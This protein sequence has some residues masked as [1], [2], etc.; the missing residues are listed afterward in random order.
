MRNDFQVIAEIPAITKFKW[1]QTMNTHTHTH[2]TIGLP[3]IPMIKSNLCIFC[4]YTAIY[5][6]AKHTRTHIHKLINLWESSINQ[7]SMNSSA[8]WMQTT[9]HNCLH[10][11]SK[12]LQTKWFMATTIR[13]Y[14]AYDANPD[15]HWIKFIHIWSEAIKHF[16]KWITKSP[17]MRRPTFSLPYISFESS[18]KHCSIDRIYH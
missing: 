18:L 6:N 9:L 3:S 12:M 13:N 14:S 16:V 8:V 11:S 5:V 17:A 2:N 15:I 10:T 1:T 4:N 7:F